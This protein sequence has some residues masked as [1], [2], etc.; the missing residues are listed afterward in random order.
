MFIAWVKGRVCLLVCLVQEDH[1]LRGCKAARGLPKLTATSHHTSF[2]LTHLN[3]TF[4]SFLFLL[5]CLLG[6]HQ[7]QRLQAA[8]CRVLVSGHSNWAADC[9]ICLCT[10]SRKA[11]KSE[12][13]YFIR[14]HLVCAPCKKNYRAKKCNYRTK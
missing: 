5:P 8:A 13:R 14:S 12:A 4:A 2:S 10:C 7:L 11:A 1:A 6:H 9:L 3:T